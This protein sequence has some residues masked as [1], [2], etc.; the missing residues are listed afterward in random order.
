M[1]KVMPTQLGAKAVMIRMRTIV[2]R[3][4][5]QPTL[6]CKTKWRKA[7]TKERRMVVEQRTNLRLNLTGRIHLSKMG[8]LLILARVPRRNLGLKEVPRKRREI[9]GIKR[10]PKIL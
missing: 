3:R 1:R 8:R 7:V 6:I 9:E 10:R 5:T 2:I 4:K